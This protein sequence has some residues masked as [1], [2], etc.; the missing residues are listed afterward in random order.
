ME[1]GQVKCGGRRDLTA[2]RRHRISANMKVRTSVAL[3]KEL[4]AAVD[5]HTGGAHRRSA[6]IERALR[7]YLRVESSRDRTDLAIINRRARRLNAEA[8]DVLSF[9][10]LP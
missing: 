10:V 9:Q 8:E 4:L 2:N 7:S 3:S 1:A 6:L 5:Q